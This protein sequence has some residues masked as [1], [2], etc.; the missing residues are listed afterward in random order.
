MKSLLT[1]SRIET[2]MKA[3][4][5]GAVDYFVNNPIRLDQCWNSYK[6]ASRHGYVPEDWRIWSD[7]IRLL[8]R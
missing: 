4:H 7:L 8:D 3:G 5:F 2:M 6:I 1:D